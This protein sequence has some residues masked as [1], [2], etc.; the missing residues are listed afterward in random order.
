[1]QKCN[2]CGNCHVGSLILAPAGIMILIVAEVE[3]AMSYQEDIVNEDSSMPIHALTPL[4][5]H[6]RDWREFV[7]A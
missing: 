2:R 7:F 4:P 3:A 1:M 6:N 5:A